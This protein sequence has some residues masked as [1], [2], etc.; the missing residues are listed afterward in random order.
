MASRNEQLQYSTTHDELVCAAPHQIG[1]IGRC[2]WPSEPCAQLPTLLAVHRI[3]GARDGPNG[4]LQNATIRA[5]ELGQAGQRAPLKRHP[6]QLITW[7]L[8]RPAS[9][10]RVE[11][12]AG[13]GPKTAAGATDSSA[14]S[15]VIS[16]RRELEG[17]FAQ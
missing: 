16:T 15:Q 14:N 11:S 17:S 6:C 13:T 3:T 9:C 1:L 10:S 8:V 4:L 12:V 7:V 5:T 2:V